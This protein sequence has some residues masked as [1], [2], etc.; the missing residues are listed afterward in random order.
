MELHGSL[1]LWE[2]VSKKRIKQLEDT[3]EKYE[4]FLMHLYVT[5]PHK[6]LRN[7]IDRLLGLTPAQMVL[8]G[9]YSG[10]STEND[11]GTI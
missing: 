9:D 1:G 4:K 7:D 5:T 2:L 3:V 6:W 8:K 11:T 10:G